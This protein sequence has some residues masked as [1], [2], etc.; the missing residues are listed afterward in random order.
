MPKHQ[1]KKVVKVPKCKCST[2][3][4]E[5]CEPVPPYSDTNWEPDTQWCPQIP[6]K[7]PPNFVQTPFYTSS[8][9]PAPEWAPNVFIRPPIYSYPVPKNHQR[10]S[11]HHHKHLHEHNEYGGVAFLRSHWK[12]DIP[13]YVYGT[14]PFSDTVNSGGSHFQ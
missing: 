3:P 10:H 12:D 13:M 7:T 6:S 2:C 8:E 14:N 4:E 1:N 11:S 9:D 5:P